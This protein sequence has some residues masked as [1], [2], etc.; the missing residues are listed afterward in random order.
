MK[1]ISFTI[2]ASMIT[3]V[4]IVFALRFLVGGPED[5]WICVN[6][7]WIKHGNPGAPMPTSGCGQTIKIGL[8]QDCA[9]NG[10][11][12]LKDFQECENVSRQWCGQ[13]G[14]NFA[15]CESAC[16]HNPSAEV[17]TMQCVPVC[18]FGEQKDLSEVDPQNATYIIE[19]QAVSFINGEA[20]VPI[21]P[22]LNNDTTTKIFEALTQGDLNNDGLADAAVI[23]TQDFGGS[24]TFYYIAA[25]IKNGQGTSGTNAVLLGDRI[26]PQNTEIRNG[27]L[28]VNYAER[29]PGEPMTVRPSIGVSKYLMLNNGVLDSV[30]QSNEKVGHVKKIYE[31]DGKNYLDFD[32]VRWLSAAEG[33]CLTELSPRSDIP[34]CN[35]NGFYILD[36]DQSTQSYAI[37]DNAAIKK[38]DGRLIDFS[39]FKNLGDEHF[40]DI[41]YRLQLS[42]GI[43]IQIIEQYIP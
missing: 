16:R 15:E 21:I 42:N 33:T 26:A 4:V 18:K 22:G 28:I 37:A 32:E 5:N 35:P 3:L 1:K 8:D 10:G 12:W 25:A 9:D 31:Q 13:A 24:G 30:K 39:N 27:V 7:Q 36:D 38:T 14:G 43:I 23:L 40:D 20:Q 19:G 29:A 41:M 17:C 6:D 11:Q 34:P 2:I